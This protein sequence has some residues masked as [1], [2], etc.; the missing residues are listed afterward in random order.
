MPK[1]EGE[2][3]ESKGSHQTVTLDQKI[4]GPCHGCQGYRERNM[5]KCSWDGGGGEGEVEDQRMWEGGLQR[6]WKDST[7]KGTSVS[8]AGERRGQMM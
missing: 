7:E 3:E 2:G 6:L 5:F 1:F 8:E 4:K